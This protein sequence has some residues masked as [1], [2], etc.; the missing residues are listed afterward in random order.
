MQSSKTHDDSWLL[1]CSVIQHSLQSWFCQP[2]NAFSCR[3]ANRSDL[4]LSA[5]LWFTLQSAPYPLCMTVTSTH[6][7]HFVRSHSPYGLVHYACP[8]PLHT[9]ITWNS[10]TLH[11]LT[12][13]ITLCLLCIILFKPLS[14]PC[15]QPYTTLFNPLCHLYTTWVNLCQHCTM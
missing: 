3:C 15:F 13:C 7:L 14:T 1:R 8:C 6:L 4:Y 9:S 5:Y 10:Y 12:Y 11:S 2:H